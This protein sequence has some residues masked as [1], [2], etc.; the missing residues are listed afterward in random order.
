[1]TLVPGEYTTYLWLDIG[2]SLA[3]SVLDAIPIVITEADYYGTGKVGW[4]GS[5][6]LPQRWYLEPDGSATPN[7][8][9]AVQSAG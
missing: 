5:F 9:E 2:N 6:V 4:R 8:I 3:D 1:M 7:V